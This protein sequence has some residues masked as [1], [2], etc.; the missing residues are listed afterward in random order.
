MLKMKDLG[1]FNKVP[2]IVT[3]IVEGNTVAL[4]TYLSE[5]WNIE[6]KIKIG[7]YFDETPLVIALVMEAFPSVK[8]LVEHGGNL[9]HKEDPAFCVAVRYCG[10]EIIRWLVAHGAKVSISR[11]IFGNA[12]VQ[13]LFG[14][15]K[16]NLSLIEEFGY[17]VAKH[18]GEAFRSAISPTEGRADFEILDFFIK[19]GVDINYNQPDMVYS[20]KPT[21]LC[22]AA[23]YADLEVC[24]YLVEHGAD[25]TLSEKDGMRPYNIAVERGDTAMADYF[26]SLE[27]DDFHNLQNKL[28][29]LKPYKLPKSLIDFLQGENLRLTF[30]PDE[31]DVEFIEFFSLIDTVLMKA[32]KQKVVRISKEIDNYSHFY[33][34]WNPK[35]KMIAFWDTEHEE[36][37][38]IASFDDFIENAAEY[39]Q[40][41]ID[42]DF[43]EQ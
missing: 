4:D 13:A 21:P 5:G 15:R 9:N 17:S 14:G 32:G 29:E 23:R 11:G 7:E 33:L 43:D 35:A 30:S 20:F 26:K 37:G 38:N 8:W 24:K 34:V 6:K 28:L 2:Q 1:N 3:D 39:M 22:V 25:V 16:E 19:H 31:Y 41:V 36:F 40:K 27:P 42:G 18:G 12:Y 10:E